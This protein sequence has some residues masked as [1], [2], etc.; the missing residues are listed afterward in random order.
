MQLGL[1]LVIEVGDHA[2]VSADGRMLYFMSERAD[3][4]MNIWKVPLSLPAPG[5]AGEPQAARPPTQVTHHTPD[6]VQAAGISN[7]EECWDRTP[8]ATR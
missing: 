1:G 7:D 2:V 8:R 4:V 6:G 5:E 3:S